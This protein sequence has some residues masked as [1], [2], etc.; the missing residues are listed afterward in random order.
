[1]PLAIVVRGAGD[2]TGPSCFSS[3][4]RVAGLPAA[5]ET[6]ASFF[7][8]FDHGCCRERRAALRQCTRKPWTGA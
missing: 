1:M 4:N 8:F 3:G 5:A 6:T 7:F 2:Q